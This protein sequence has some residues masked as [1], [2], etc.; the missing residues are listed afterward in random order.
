MFL[1][2][3]VLQIFANITEKHLRWSLLLTKLK[4]PQVQVFSYEIYEILMN[5]FEENLR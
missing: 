2:I 1:K 3:G 5:T 4:N